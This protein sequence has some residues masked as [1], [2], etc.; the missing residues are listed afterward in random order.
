MWGRVRQ[1]LNEVNST[2]AINEKIKI[3][4]KYQDLRDI[5]QRVFDKSTTTG[6][7]EKSIRKKN[8]LIET[9]E[10]KI[11]DNICDLYDDLAARRLTGHAAIASIR[12][13]A[14]RHPLY[15]D[16][17]VLILT[18]NLKTRLGTKQMN[19]AFPGLC[20]EFTVALAT[21]FTKA[22]KHFAKFPTFDW[23]ISRKYDGVRCLTVVRNGTAKC[24]SREGKPFPALCKME[25]E[26]ARDFSTL[27]DCIVFDGEICVVDEEGNENF[28]AAVSQVRRKSAI[29]QNYKYYVFDV[30]RFEEFYGIS[31]PSE[32]F[33]DRV[34]HG[35]D[36]IRKAGPPSYMQTVK[37]VCYEDEESL[38]R[39]KS[40]C[41]SESWEGLM[42]RLNAPYKGKRSKDILKIKNFQIEEFRVIGR[43]WAPMRIIEDGL[44]KEEEMLSA[45]EISYKGHPVFV[46]SGFTIEQRREFYKNPDLIMGKQISVQFFEETTNK[47]G[48]PSL[49]FPTFKYLWDGKKRDV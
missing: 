31:E 18:K 36:L 10:C 40:V 11:Y 12:R 47:D 9:I 26:I 7:T 15:E 32:M 28:Q 27:C 21:D 38:R 33:I 3:T 20:P 22:R 6:M 1:Y 30:L 16:E 46:G 49:R 35:Y 29:M 39:L 19:K 23:Y 8:D 17:I 25:D 41:E 14:K 48:K 5:F 44:E 42:L 43:T 4:R 45:V 2:N 34:Q 37:H 24:F 13:Y